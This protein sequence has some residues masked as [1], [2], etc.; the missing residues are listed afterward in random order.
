M[1]TV[2][3][4]NTNRGGFSLVEVL[5]ALVIVAVGIV[6]ILLILPMTLERQRVNNLRSV[7]GKTA[8][9]ELNQ[10]KASDANQNFFDWLADNKLVFVNPEQHFE[11][12]FIQAQVV[13]CHSM[14]EY[15]RGLYRV[16]LGLRLWD[17]R[18]E[19]YTTYVTDR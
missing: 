16:T 19:Y 10:I 17:N 1:N 9:T 5:V 8:Q 12:E 4:K 3:M 14:G 11:S 15:N 2:T 7:A 13:S 6:S 18:M